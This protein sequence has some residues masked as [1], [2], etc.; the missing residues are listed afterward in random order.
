MWL[1]VAAVRAE[2]VGAH[3]TS[4]AEIMRH[5]LEAWYEETECGFPVCIYSKSQ[6]AFIDRVILL[7]DHEGLRSVSGAKGSAGAK[8]CCHCTNVLSLGREC[9]PGYTDISEMSPSKFVRQTDEGL[10]DIRSHFATCRTKKEKK[11]CETMLGWNADNLEKSALASPMLRPWIRLNSFMLDAMHQYHSCGQI[12]QEL[13]LWFT[14]FLDCGHT[15]QLL[16]QW[17]SIGWKASQGDQPPHLVCSDKLFKYDLDY[18]GDASACRIALP[19]AWAFSLEV[20]DEDDAMKD[21]V[22]SIS[23][24]YAVVRCL[25]RA[26]ICASHG[27][28]LLAFQRKHMEAFQQAYGVSV[29]RPKAHYALH[30][31]EQM[32]QWQRLI[33]CH[34]GERKHR[35]FKKHVGPKISRLEGYAKSVLLHLTEMELSGQE[36]AERYTGQAIGIPRESQSLAQS[37]R[38]QPDAAFCSGYEIGCVSYQR[39][40]FLRMSQECCVEVRG[41]V[42]LTEQLRR[43]C[44]RLAL[45]EEVWLEFTLGSLR[46]E[47][48]LLADTMLVTR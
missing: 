4:Y 26:K 18:R 17:V 36:P 3:E 28:H 11:E 43:W 32:Q 14:R 22:Q 21:A 34:V 40:A 8:P 25:Q 39:G 9:P 6:L 45:R 2:D 33:D 41:G 15:L 10:M 7:N 31:T 48:L 12:A 16:Q 27:E 5:L 30:L 38:L 46:A 24:L 20:L 23:A 47:C 29:L 13:G 1:P 42:P 44:A 35:L 37:L 19:L